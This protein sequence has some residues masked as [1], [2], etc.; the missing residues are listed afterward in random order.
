MNK[1]IFWAI[2]DALETR[3]DYPLSSKR[4]SA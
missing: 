2:F 3:T 4:D 1:K